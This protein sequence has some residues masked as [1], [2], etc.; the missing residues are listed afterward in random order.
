MVSIVM[1]KLHNQKQVGEEMVDFIHTPSS[2]EVRAE[3]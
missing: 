1:I 2:R 3:T